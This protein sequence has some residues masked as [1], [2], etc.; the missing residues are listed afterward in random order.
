MEKTWGIVLGSVHLP[1]GKTVV[2]IF[3]ETRGT[4]PFL[5][6]NTHRNTS[7]V[8]SLLLMPLHV[9]EIDYEYRESRELQTLKEVH[10]MRQ[11]AT[12]PYDPLKQTM[13]LFLAEFLTHALLR[14]GKNPALLHY[15]TEAL[16]YLDDAESDFTSMHVEMLRGIVDFL[17][18]G[19]PQLQEMSLQELVA[20]YR[21][22]VPEFPELSSLAVL[23]DVLR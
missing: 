2:R 10:L 8:R 22:V 17:G 6:H 23:H 5:V 20:Y 12:I 21:E 14:E 7:G 13:A 4:V 16:R 1:G 18:Y 9:V 3:T 15:I 11:Y 19:T